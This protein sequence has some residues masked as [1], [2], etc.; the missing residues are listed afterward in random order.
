MLRL[1]IVH[2]LNASGYVMILYNFLHA[3]E[4]RL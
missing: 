4:S 1:V 3:D 2:V